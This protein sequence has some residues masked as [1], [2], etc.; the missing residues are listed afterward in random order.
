MLAHI[1]WVGARPIQGMWPWYVSSCVDAAK[2]MEARECEDQGSWLTCSNR[3]FYR[4]MQS[5]T[6]CSQIRYW[7][8]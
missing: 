2:G 7:R 3:L 4:Y 8:Q 5:N 6:T 1:A